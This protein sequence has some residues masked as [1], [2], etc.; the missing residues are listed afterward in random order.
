MVVIVFVM[1]DVMMAV[2]HTVLVDVVVDV[3]VV[4]GGCIPKGKEKLESRLLTPS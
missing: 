2:S 4:V 1:V 3:V